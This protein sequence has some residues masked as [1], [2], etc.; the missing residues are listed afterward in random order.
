MNKDSA[1]FKKWLPIF[2]VSAL[3]IIFYKLIGNIDTVMANIGRLLNIMSPF[4]FG[5]LICYFLY[6]PC[7][8]LEHVYKNIKTKFISDRARLFS[9]LSV[10][11]LVLLAIT[12]F[13]MI[14]VPILITS[15]TE[16][17]N[18][19]PHYYNHILTY[20]DRLP[21]TDINIKAKLNDFAASILSLLLDPAKIEQIARSI[22]GFANGIFVA[23]ISLIV[24]LYILLDR[25]NIFAF[26]SKLST[27]FLKNETK[28]QMKKY[29]N[30]INNVT[31]IF[32]ASKGLDSIINWVCV[33]ALL[34]TFNV[35]YAVLLGIIAG[36]ANFIPY[37]G[38]LFAVIFISLLTILTGGINLAIKTLICLIIFQQLDANFIE[39]KI[40]GSSLKISPILVIFSVIVGGA[41]FGVVGMFLAVPIAAILKQILIE[42]IESKK[43]AVSN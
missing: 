1:T 31:F 37:L 32:I 18:E 6:T 8:K 24:S 27:A 16:L 35:R 3:L 28:I 34:L 38:S 43:Q 10:Y 4:L 21:A 14:V 25:E 30:Q 5:I 23:V 7:Q 39:P 19:I 2:V 13:I 26:F 11:S 12:S 41:Y 9:V 22:V 17:A 15:L 40:M 36:L 42:Y 33:T 20:I 29:L